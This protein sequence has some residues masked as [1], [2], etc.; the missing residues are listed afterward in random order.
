M[1]SLAPV[2]NLETHIEAIMGHIWWDCNIVVTHRLV[3][4]LIMLYQDSLRP[5]VL[6]SP[7]VQRQKSEIWIKQTKAPV[8]N[9]PWALLTCAEEHWSRVRGPLSASSPD[10]LQ[11]CGAGHSIEVATNA[12][13]G[14]LTCWLTP[15]WTAHRTSAC[16]HTAYSEGKYKD[17]KYEDSEKLIRVLSYMN[18]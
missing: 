4:I 14:S 6:F 17:G 10:E 2:A 8:I 16:P 1:K 12:S 9:K 13:W 5:H 3:D 15:G 7:S 11:L 18:M